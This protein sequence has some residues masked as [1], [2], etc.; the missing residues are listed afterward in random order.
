MKN[1][2]KKLFSNK[3]LSF[4]IWIIITMIIMSF[5]GTLL[6]AASTFLNLIGVV[7]LLSWC[8]ISAE[9]KMFLNLYE[10]DNY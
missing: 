7:L 2:I 9:T 1:W 4:V 8:Y 5:I 10:K 6:T 3:F